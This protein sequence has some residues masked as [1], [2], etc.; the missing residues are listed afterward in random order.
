L[1]NKETHSPKSQRKKTATIYEVCRKNEKEE[2]T[3]K[4][5]P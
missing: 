5:K 1:T 4:C 2:K 3:N